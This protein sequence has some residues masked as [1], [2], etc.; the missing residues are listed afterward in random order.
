[1]NSFVQYLFNGLMLGCL[2]ALIAVGYTMVY[3]IIELINFA[4]GELFMFGAYIT[5]M[6][7]VTVD[8]SVRV[9]GA[10]ARSE[11]LRGCAHRNGGRGNTGGGHRAAGLSALAERAAAGGADLGH[12]GIDPAA[13]CG[14]GHLRLAVAVVPHYPHLHGGGRSGQVVRVRRSGDHVLPG[15]R[16]HRDG[17]GDDRPQPVRQSH[18]DG[19]GHAGFGPGQAHVGPH[20]RQRQPGHRH[21]LSHRLG[22]GGARRRLVRV[23]VSL[24]RSTDGVRPGPEGLHRRGS[25]WYREHPGSL[26]GRRAPRHHRIV[27]RRLRELAL[28]VGL[29]LRSADPPA[30]LQAVNGLLGSTISQKA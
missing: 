6:M 9:R 2:Y 3:G 8:L 30:L 17:R 24:R 22:H 11:L 19:A 5:I 23:G 1:M 14:P 13:E 26:P 21:H 29:R 16:R 4:F 25:R 28:P 15:V 18:Q 7:M 20:G 12:R 27:R 10:H